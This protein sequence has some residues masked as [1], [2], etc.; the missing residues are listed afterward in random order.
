MYA[1]V[2][3][4]KKSNIVKVPRDFRPSTDCLQ[5]TVAFLRIKF[6]KWGYG[7]SSSLAQELVQVCD[8]ILSSLDKKQSPMRSPY[9]N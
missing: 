2:G 4:E 1:G 9:I 5:E 6:Q 7:Q 3:H 8:L